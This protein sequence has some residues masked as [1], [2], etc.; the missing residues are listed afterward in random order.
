MSSWEQYPLNGYRFIPFLETSGTE[1]IFLFLALLGAT[2][3]KIYPP[4]FRCK[5]ISLLLPF[6]CIFLQFPF[7]CPFSLISN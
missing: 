4:F 2:F 1:V 5:A 6:F 3:G 7:F